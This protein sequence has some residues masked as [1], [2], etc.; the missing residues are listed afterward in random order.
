MFWKDPNYGAL[1]FIGQY[2]Y[3]TRNPWYVPVNAPKSA[4]DNTMY[5]DLRYTLPG[6]VQPSPEK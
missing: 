3:A 6:G 5:L 1:N 4:H 2:E